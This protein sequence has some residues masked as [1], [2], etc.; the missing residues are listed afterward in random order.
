MYDI[1]LCPFCGSKAYPEFC[2][3]LM[4]S[5]VVECINHKCK[6]HGPRV[7]VP[8]EKQGRKRWEEFASPYRE[9]SVFRWNDRVSCVAK[10][11]C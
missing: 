8:M 5:F 9:E 11:D 2:Q 7:R 6:A 4:F 3:D 1:E 10:A